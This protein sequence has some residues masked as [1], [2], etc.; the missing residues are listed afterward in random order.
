MG[1]GGNQMLSY[2]KG[3]I[4]IIILLTVLLGC[5]KLP[6]NASQSLP[7][8]N[9]VAAEAQKTI[10]SK[11]SQLNSHNSMNPPIDCPLHGQGINLDDL[12]P[13]ADV[14]KYIDFLERKDRAIWQKPDAVIRELHLSGTE[15]IADVGAGSGYF[16]FRLAQT[17]PHGMVYAIDIEPEMLRYI[18][19]KAMTGGINNIEV[20]KSN[21]D[22]PKVPSGIDLVFVCDVIHHVPDRETWLKEL[23]AQM[24]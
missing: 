20:I 12:K 11:S 2:I 1:P 18:H 8:K 22:N 24:K 14:Q 21:P 23:S 4:K 15:K 5:S 7:S 16:T 19:H 9:E 10:E 6:S 17:V 3:L 13:F